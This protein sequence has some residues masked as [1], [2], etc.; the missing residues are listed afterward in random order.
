MAN[1]IIQSTSMLGLFDWVV[2]NSL[3]N[4]LKLITSLFKLLG[5]LLIDCGALFVKGGLYAWNAMMTMSLS[6]VKKSP[7]SH[8][9][10]WFFVSRGSIYTTTMA[11]GSALL[12]TYF[13]IGWLKDSIDIRANFTLE[14][15]FKLF[16]RLAITAGL[17]ANSSAL[18]FGITNTC[19][20]ITSTV[21]T[22]SNKTDT[23]KLADDAFSGIKKNLEKEYK[24]ADKKSNSDASLVNMKWFVVG[25]EAI[26]GGLAAMAIIMVS[27][28]SI[29]VTVLKRL[30]KVY[31]CIPFGPIALAGF[32]GGQEMFST[33]I[34]WLKTFIGYL[35]EAFV[36]AIA[37]ALSYKL[38][39]DMNFHFAPS[40]SSNTNDSVVLM[41]QSLFNLCMPMACTAACV[42]G[43]DGVVR[44]CLG[45]GS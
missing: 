40:T 12:V 15:M 26:L 20:A 37:I 27:G 25:F 35:M 13:L 8:A 36:I 7:L 29:L 14:N 21:S 6:E 23:M 24:K 34:T 10:A 44:S 19:V 39:K 38:F 45:L 22:P 5:D 4:I 9:E 11:V 1:L 30:F 32:A 42:K 16:I 17:V 41:I 31:M 28:V 43:A 18:T 2:D 33:G 3:G